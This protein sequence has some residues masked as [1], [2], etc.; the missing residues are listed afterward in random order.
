MEKLK[1]LVTAFQNLFSEQ[2]DNQADKYDYNY[3]ISAKTGVRNSIL[4]QIIDSK[5]DL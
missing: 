1:F 5:L 2:A 4:G 3:N